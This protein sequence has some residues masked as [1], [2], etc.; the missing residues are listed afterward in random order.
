[1]TTHAT[2]IKKIL[3]ENGYSI[4]KQRQ[5][6][7]ELLVGQEP[8][9]LTE[10]YEQVKTKLDRT[11][12]YRTVTL[13]ERIGIVKRVNIG[14]K[15]KVELSD[16]FA[17]HHHHLTCLKCHRITPISEN[18]LE[19]FMNNLSAKHLFTPV[20]HQVEIQGYCAACREQ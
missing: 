10:L 13:F 11:S 4:T 19:E 14:W 16:Q 3:R 1:M 15:Y 12:V 18:E 20:E 2:D 9:S 8:R 5:L 7:F 6:I 17:E